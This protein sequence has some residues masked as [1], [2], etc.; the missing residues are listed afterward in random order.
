[1]LINDL[2]LWPTNTG[3]CLLQFLA[4][5]SHTEATGWCW[6]SESC[7]LLALSS[8]TNC[9]YNSTSVFL[10]LALTS[11][12][13]LLF[14]NV[15]CLSV[16]LKWDPIIRISLNSFGKVGDLKM[17]ER[18]L[19]I[20]FWCSCSSLTF[21][22][23]LLIYYLSSGFCL[24]IHMESVCFGSRVTQSCLNHWHVKKNVLTGF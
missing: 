18:Q 11:P 10:Q 13:I 15:S 19:L 8:L 21:H 17:K 9:I 22:W 12:Q 20:L 24:A 6:T 23:Y 3:V 16:R 7:H 2:S 4:L 5:E 14:Y 1:M